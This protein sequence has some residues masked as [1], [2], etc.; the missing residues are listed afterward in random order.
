[1]LLQGDKRDFGVVAVF[2][3]ND[4]PNGV[5][6]T[7]TVENEKFDILGGKCFGQPGRTGCYGARSNPNP[8]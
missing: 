1:M 8:W 7:I 3:F 4:L 5:C 6:V 2:L